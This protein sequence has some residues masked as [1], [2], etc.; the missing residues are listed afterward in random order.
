MATH[1]T[2]AEPEP[3]P[4]N[5]VQA[6]VLQNAHGR[7]LI[8]GLGVYLRTDGGTF[9]PQGAPSKS[10]GEPAFLKMENMVRVPLKSLTKVGID[11]LFTV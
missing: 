11:W 10:D 4:K 5:R 6:M 9:W 3:I 8:N 1:P 7:R 2:P